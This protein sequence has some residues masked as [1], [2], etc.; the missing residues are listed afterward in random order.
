MNAYPNIERRDSGPAWMDKTADEFY[1]PESEVTDER[2]EW[3]DSMF[4]VE[5]LPPEQEQQLRGWE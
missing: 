1:A 5:H 3:A 4:G 2:G